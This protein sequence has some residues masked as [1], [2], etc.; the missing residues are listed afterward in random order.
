MSC[1]ADWFDSP[2]GPLP[3][4]LV[5]KY[6]REILEGKRHRSADMTDIARASGR[7]G[8]CAGLAYLHDKGILHRDIKG[9]NILVDGVSEPFTSSTRHMCT[10][11]CVVFIFCM[12]FSLSFFQNGNA[13]LS[14]FGACHKVENLKSS[15]LKDGPTIPIKGSIYWMAPEVVHEKAGTNVCCVVQCMK[16]RP[17]S[18]CPA[19]YYASVCV[20]VCMQVVAATYGV[21]AVWSSK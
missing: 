9:A 14:D 11:Q 15:T 3:L 5:R 21:W 12:P 17:L 16:I 10:A 1:L 19:G 6:T 8:V 18:L 13:K 4:R 2:A 20:F 7:S